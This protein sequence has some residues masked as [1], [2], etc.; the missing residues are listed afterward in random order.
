M[1][2]TVDNPISYKGNQFTK[3]AI[4]CILENLK[5]YNATYSQIARSYD[6]SATKIIDIFDT[7]VQ[8]PRKNSL[9][10]Y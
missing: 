9:A 10:F 3:T 7:F 6:V 8:I 4:V 1:Y 2:P 5:P